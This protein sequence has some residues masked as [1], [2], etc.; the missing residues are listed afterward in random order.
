[1]L[2]VNCGTNCLNIYVAPVSSVSC[3][4]L[5]NWQVVD[6]LADGMAFGALEACKECTGQLVFKGDAYYCTGDISAWTKC[7]FKTATPVRKDWVT[8]K[9]GCLISGLP[10]E[11]PAI[12]SEQESCRQVFQPVTN[13]SHISLGAIADKVKSK[14]PSIPIIFNNFQW[15]LPVSRFRNFTRFPSWKNSSSSDRTGCTPKWLPPKPWLQLKPNPWR[16]HPVPQLSHCQRER[17]QV[18]EET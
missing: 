6:C 3:Q 17:L 14:M 2:C 13:K 12:V 5:F 7:V 9:V 1:M 18:S 10:S 4:V 8:P 11:F 15:N 16:V